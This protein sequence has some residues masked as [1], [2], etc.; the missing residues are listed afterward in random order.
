MISVE[1]T[2]TDLNQLIYN[3]AFDYLKKKY[4]KVSS[5]NITTGVVTKY[6]YGVDYVVV[7][8]TIELLHTVGAVGDVLRIVRETSTSEQIV[9]WNDA[10]ILKA[11][12]M[13]L[14]QLQ[15]LH[16]LEEYSEYMSTNSLSLDING[17][18]D[19]KNSRIVNLSAPQTATDA[20]NRGYIDSFIGTLTDAQTS[21]T[22]AQSWA[23]GDILNRPE[24]SSKYWAEQA[25]LITNGDL[26]LKKDGSR[27]LDPTY[28]PT[29]PQAVATKDYVDRQL[30]PS[31]EL[32]PISLFMSSATALSFT[33]P[34]VDVVV[35]YA[36]VGTGSV[37]QSMIYTYPQEGYV[38]AN[39]RY[40]MEFYFENLTVSP[41]TTYTVTLTLVVKGITIFTKAD[42]FVADLTSKNFQMFINTL[43]IVADVPYIAGDTGTL[44]ITISKN[45]GT[46]STINLVSRVATNK[47]TVFNR[48][49][50]QVYTTA[51]L[52]Y[53][54][55]DTKTQRDRN[56][57]FDTYRYTGIENNIISGRKVSG[58]S[59]FTL[60]L[61]AGAN[62]INSRRY[63]RLA[64]DITLSPRSVNL[65]YDKNDGT[66]GS[67]PA[68]YPTAM[69]DNNTVGFWVFNQAGNIPNSAVGISSIAVANDLVPTGGITTVDGWVG[70]SRQ[71]DGTSGYY[72]SQNNTGIPIG[73]NT[74]EFTL[75]FTVNSIASRSNVLLTNSSGWQI[76]YDSS[77]N[78]TF[79]NGTTGYASG[80][81]VEVGKTYKLKVHL[82]S[83]SISIYV[84]GILI[85]VGT[86]TVNTTTS[87]I[88]VGNYLSGT[89]YCGVTLHYLEVR[90]ALRTDEQTAQ[91]ANKLLLPC[92]YTDTNGKRKNI[93][94]ILPAN[95]ISLGIVKATS[96]GITAYNDTDY[97]Y[98]RRE[99]AYGGN[100]RVFLGWKLVNAGQ[101][102]V[103]YVNVLGTENI[104]VAEIWY[105]KALTDN[106][107]SVI[108]VHY[109]NNY[110]Y[111]LFVRSVNPSK[112]TL[113]AYNG[114]VIDGINAGESNNP[115][116]G[117]IGVWAEV[118]E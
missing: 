1:Y 71:L 39:G 16:I 32:P 105:K 47:F 78:I 82:N 111:G 33:K 31:F 8:S 108:D 74:R 106:K 63:D 53:N 118:L 95:S 84:T 43:S 12:D 10:S 61:T 48:L 94:E 11:S 18:Y 100:R 103:D 25:N 98:G 114:Y 90:N 56:I 85:Y 113:W 72:V 57:E 20:V 64:N 80:Y 29:V 99:G 55:I 92:F 77:G 40:N 49:N 73:N 37:S 50:T 116:S 69:I 14:A 75:M 6:T 107:H 21:A 60:G 112:V 52:D 87:N 38:P 17:Q 41:N 93:T 104:S 117:Y 81:I 4:I 58:V 22:L 97:T 91:I 9:S 24:G 28:Y 15:Q 34:T 88:Y 2:I 76:S 65:M 102:A 7:D 27:P 5:K 35:P 68:V 42:S 115:T 110:Y 79:H 86:A 36:L 89:F 44:T 3:F 101:G 13:S 66:T 23:I 70:Y 109:T 67:V 45:T 54:G 30:N 59:N 51:V 26:W 46:T 96:V 62:W 83:G 19:A